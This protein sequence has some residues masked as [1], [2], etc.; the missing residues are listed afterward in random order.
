MMHGPMNIK[1]KKK[2]KT[3][4]FE[5]SFA[6][7]W[8]KGRDAILNYFF[9]LCTLLCLVAAHFTIQST[10]LCF[11]FLCFVNMFTSAQNLVV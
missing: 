4:L 7:S 8:E 2:K 10:I 1:G 3:S 9:F 5:S 6:L 11:Q